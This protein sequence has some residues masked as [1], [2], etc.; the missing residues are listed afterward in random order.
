MEDAI[1]R[2]IQKEFKYL[3]EYNEYIEFIQ[4]KESL[5]TLILCDRYKKQEPIIQGLDFDIIRNVLNRF[6][7]RHLIEFFVTKSNALLYV[8]YFEQ[9]GEKD[10]K[11]QNDVEESK[12]IQEMQNLYDEADKYL[13]LSLEKFRQYREQ[14]VFY[15]PEENFEQDDCQF[16]F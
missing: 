11:R 4:L 7:T 1:S 14:R 16:H 9:M 3:N 6:N 5:R 13:K 10:A 8:H 2:F 12:L 15:M